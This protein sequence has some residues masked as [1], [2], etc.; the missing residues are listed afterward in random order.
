MAEVFNIGNKLGE[1]LAAEITGD[2]VISPLGV[3]SLAAGAVVPSEVTLANGKILIGGAGGVATA[4]DVSGDVT[5]SAEGVITVNAPK[6]KVLTQQILAT[7]LTDGTAAVG[8]V[9]M[10]GAIP[11]G[12]ILLA[13]K[14]TVTTGFAGDVSASLQIGDGTDV[15]R[16]MTGTPSIFANAGTGIETGVPSG[17]KLVLTVFNPVITVT[18]AA[19]ITPVIAGAGD[20]TVSI[21]YLATV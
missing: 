3:A 12:A 16:L 13:S 17:A 8:T 15:D 6:I 10:T 9:S 1:A 18:S 19:D 2:V 14:V 7:S 20:M 4:K 5:L 21:Y 11:A